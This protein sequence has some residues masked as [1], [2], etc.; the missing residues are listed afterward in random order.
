VKHSTLAKRHLHLDPVGGIAGDMF[1]AAMLD[2]FPECLDA[3][4][5]DLA[6]SGVLEH[7]NINLVTGKSA[8][9]AVKRFAV[10]L[11]S[12]TPRTTGHYRDLVALLNA[13]ALDKKV[14]NRTLAL[15]EILARAE[16]VVHGVD[17]NDVHFHEVADWDSVADMVAAASVIEHS[18][19]NSWS[20][21]PLPTGSGLVST[22][23]GLLPVPAPAT[24]LLMEGLASW[25][26]GVPGERVTPTGAAIVQYLSTL[27][28]S[29]YELKQR[30]QGNVANV[31]MGAGQRDLIDR[32]N[33]VRCTLTISSESIHA[34]A[35]DGQPFSRLPQAAFAHD[36]DH[37]VQLSFAID[38]M[39]S[40]E[41]SVALQHI[42]HSQGVLD[43]SHGI[44]YGKKGRMMFEVRVL[45]EPQMEPEISRLCFAETS[46][47][48]LRVQ[49]LVRRVLKR[50]LFRFED[51]QGYAGIKRVMRPQSD[52]MQEQTTLKI[53]DDDLRRIAG[54]AARR[55]RSE[56]LAKGIDKTDKVDS[57]DTSVKT[58]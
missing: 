34:N 32:P 21:G 48:G 27:N 31:G 37:V 40:E 14:L 5:A 57:T 15:F 39:T 10:E 8:G 23:H 47:L 55:E 53:E 41:L 20:C 16:S 30:P 56:Q 6:S 28:S 33:I 17:I 2:A 9:L 49:Q 38:D 12:A 44:S 11:V 29:S 25:D 24:L 52:P 22:E 42:R 13:S 54:L 36:V 7:V 35:S 58:K 46:T 26:D 51:E 3:C 43:V 45:C 4:L 50:E 18:N 19:V 1:N